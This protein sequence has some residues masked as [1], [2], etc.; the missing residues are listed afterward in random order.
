DVNANQTNPNTFATGGVTEFDIVDDVVALTGSG[1]ADAPYLRLYLN[2]TG[3]SNIT[4]QYNL[5]DIDGS[6][7]NA[8]QQVA[9]HYRVGASGTWTDV[10]AA[11]VADATTGPSLAT[12]ITPVCVVLPAATSN[13]AVIQLRVMTTNATG[14]DEWVGVDDVVVTSAGCGGS[15]NLSIDNVTLAEGDAGTTNFLFTVTLSAAA[16]AGGVTFDIATADGTA[17]DDNP[18]TE[19]NDYVA[20]ALTGQTIAAGSSTYNFTVAV[21]GDAVVEPNETFLVNVTLVT[22]ANV[23]D[24]QGQGTISNDDVPLS[25]IHD[26]QGSGASTPVPGTTVRVIGVVVGDFQS[27]AQLQGFFLEEESA[28][29]D[30]N[31]DTSEGIFVFCGGCPTAVNLGDQ[32]QVVGTAQ[33][34]FGMTEISATTAPSLAVLSSGNPLPP[35][36]VLDLP[37][38]GVI[39]DYY[40]PREAMRVSF[41][42]TLTVAEYFE[43]AR[44]GQVELYEGGRPRQFTEAA[45]PSVAGNAAH[46][47]DLARRRVILDDDDNAQNSA[48]SLADG[49]EFLYHPQANGGLSIGAHG[50]DFFRG[51]DL[52]TA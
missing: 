43:L 51:G 23:V 46:L 32:V 14:N 8:A 5:R 35:P 49:F 3:Q 10:P 1:T 24:G 47:D 39:N 17:E 29:F 27:G 11:Y 7:D 41:S 44:F 50:T 12:L 38:V 45:L 28:D 31:P 4:V 20:Q 36:A 22:G 42:D 18:P 13:Q 9:L 21:N 25:F 19:D 2:T 40:E 48:L 30:A 16:G 37:V 6:V 52:V 15:P 26:V 33:E 34:F